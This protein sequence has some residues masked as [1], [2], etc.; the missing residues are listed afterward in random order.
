M[1]EAFYVSG[2]R[3]WW[4]WKTRCLEGAVPQGVS[5]RIRARASRDGRLIA[6]VTP[7]CS[8]KL[9]RCI[10]FRHGAMGRLRVWRGGRRADR[11]SAGASK[12]GPGRIACSPGAPFTT[13]TIL[14]ILHGLAGRQARRSRRRLSQCI[15]RAEQP[16]RR[17]R[18]ARRLAARQPARSRAR[19]RAGA[20]ARRGAARRRD[21][22]PLPRAR[23]RKST[24]LNSSHGYISYAVF[25]L[26]KKKKQPNKDDKQHN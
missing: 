5:V 7:G 18:R 21:H 10:A 19:P 16:P 12:A 20:A 26:K 1:A 4:N 17:H 24:R 22:Q 2:P 3:W 15:E 9:A 11:L 13:S 8:R 6:A 23:D 25:C 14:E